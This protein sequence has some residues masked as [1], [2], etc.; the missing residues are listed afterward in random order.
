MCEAPS[1]QWTSFSGRS[2]ESCAN[3]S[4]VR[5]GWFVT[6]RWLWQKMADI[7]SWPCVGFQMELNPSSTKVM[8]VPPGDWCLVDPTT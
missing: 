7:G 2:P 8:V 4:T 5:S 6:Q 1:Y 3:K